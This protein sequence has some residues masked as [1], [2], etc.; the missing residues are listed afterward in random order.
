MAK[1]LQ[2]K[3]Q[4]PKSHITRLDNE[5]ATS[6]AIVSLLKKASSN[7]SIKQGD[8]MVFFFAGHGGR[9]KGLNGWKTDDGRVETICPHDMGAQDD[10][11]KHIYGIPDFAVA[12]HLGRLAARGVN[13]VS[14]HQPSP[15]FPLT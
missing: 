9:S 15:L 8:L 10:G 2:E 12:S 3:L 4:V 7:D 1:F 14:L 6:D 5:A 13:V 11:G